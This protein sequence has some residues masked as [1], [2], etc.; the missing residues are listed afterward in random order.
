MGSSHLLTSSQSTTSTQTLTQHKPLKMTAL[1]G[2][3]AVLASMAAV[4]LLVLLMADQP[5]TAVA[6]GHKASGTA[7]IVKGSG[8]WCHYCKCEKGHVSCKG[9]GHH[10]HGKKF[11][12]GKMEGQYCHCDFRSCKKGYGKKGYGKCH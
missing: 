6:G 1:L 3:S 9:H 11:C 10:G 7:C 2:R 4:L 8:C 12:Y 5:S